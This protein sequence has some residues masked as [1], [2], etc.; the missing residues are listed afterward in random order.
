MVYKSYVLAKPKEA[1][2]A[3]TG[4]A[5]VRNYATIPLNLVRAN[6][7]VPS[8]SNSTLSKALK[9]GPNSWRHVK[10]TFMTDK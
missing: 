1:T 3:Q 5:K 7:E 6:L 10:A 8:R 9:L 4:S 2:I